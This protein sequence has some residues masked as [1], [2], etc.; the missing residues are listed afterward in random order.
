MVENKTILGL[1]NA[2]Q[3]EVYPQVWKKH[4]DDPDLLRVLSS[5]D[6]QDVS[7]DEIYP[8]PACF[9]FTRTE[10]FALTGDRYGLIAEGAVVEL[11]P[12]VLMSGANMGKGSA[13]E[14]AAITLIKAG[15]KLITA[16][17]F[18]TTFR[19]NCLN[20]GLLTSTNPD[21]VSEIIR[22]SKIPRKK[23]VSE[24]EGTEKEILES[25]GLFS[26]NARRLKGELQPPKIETEKRPMTM[27][28]KIIAKHLSTS[29]EKLFVKPGDQ[30]FVS[31]DWRFSYEVFTALIKQL[32]QSGE[33]AG[34][35]IN[36]P[37][38]VLL[39]A[40]HFILSDNPQVPVLLENQ[41][42]FTE[43]Q[44]IKE[45]HAQEDGGICHLVMVQDYI[46]PGDF[47][48]G[49]DS[50]TG[51]GGVLGALCL[52]V[53]ATAMA[54]SLITKD[55]LVKIP[56]TLRIDLKGRLN[57]GVMAKDVMLYILSQPWIRSRENL[58]K[59][60]EY[61]GE[62]LKG[63]SFDEQTV[64]SNMTAEAEGKAGI[65]EPNKIVIDYLVNKRG[66]SQKEV[67]N[68]LVGSDDN[69]EFSATKE[70]DLSKVEPMVA[71]P[72]D[73]KNAIPVS[74]LKQTVINKAFIGSCTGGKL[75]DLSAVAEVLKGNFVNKNVELVVQP[76]SM[77]I[78]HQA[79]KEGL[80]QI[81][82][83]AGAQVVLPACGA[84]I[85]EGP[86]KV[87]LKEVVISAS[88]RNF[89]GRMGEGD[90]YLANPRV[91][92]ASAIAG[93]ICAG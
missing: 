18:N 27:A 42:D 6:R 47:V 81:F 80:L 92:A 70:I 34:Y 22:T 21:V 8:V 72:G 52:P 9:Y 24:F 53:G 63:L 48:I 44:Q 50:H 4:T 41:S 31:A 55:T 76:A 88:N 90:A 57:K 66:L 89:K 69:A 60:F 49:T 13:R 38:S 5:A 23:I 65:V 12:G 51:T 84:C 85:G 17:S 28:E 3:F 93:F 11:K 40:D 33:L 19:E 77:N 86:G 79:E 35:E 71:L 2:G 68:L 15:I 54:N 32:L 87:G 14:H 16:P 10:R 26:Y 43:S 64:L 39:F 56:E 58:G 73:P 25:G 83:K 74:Q 46:K 62:G 78:Y 36:D 82:N 61:G 1:T 30:A 91:V 67:D 59:I 37:S 75:D 45:S 20:L 7:T 29:G